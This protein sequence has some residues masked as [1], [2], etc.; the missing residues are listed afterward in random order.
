MCTRA[1]D[2][3][4]M[5]QK[6]GAYGQEQR[7]RETRHLVAGGL[8]DDRAEEP[9]RIRLVPHA[10]LVLGLILTRTH[11]CAVHLAHHVRA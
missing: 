8:G 3:G 11:L 2:G 1:L 7:Q 4:G 6:S 5:R 10:P 9:R